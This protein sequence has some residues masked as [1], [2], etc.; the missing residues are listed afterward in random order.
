MER[1]LQFPRGEEA[2]MPQ[3]WRLTPLYLGIVW[4]TTL[5]SCARGGQVKPDEMSASAH[6]DEAR[7][8]SL[9]A[10]NEVGHYR[11]T[12]AQ[13]RPFS[14][15]SGGDYLYSVPV[16]N[17]TDAH[18]A[19]AEAHRDHARQ[20]ERAARYLERYEEYECRDFPP[21][22]RAAC[23]LIGPVV[24]VDDIAGG[25]RVK[26]QDGARVDAI[27]AHM[28]CHYAFARARAF[29]ETASCPLYL[30]G[31]EIR[32]GMDPTS[33]E[34]TTPDRTQVDEVRRRSREEAVFVH[35]PAASR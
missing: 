2:T 32:R 28:R 8:E 24:H 25:V 13:P 16:Y 14:D 17:P 6:H 20:H 27:V 35:T 12:G 30:R 23:P 3:L 18:M 21:A 15:T 29:A 33:V 22:S 1:A 7:R 11:S 9:A 31:I 10:Q 19:A 26:L 4:A 5:I 34:I